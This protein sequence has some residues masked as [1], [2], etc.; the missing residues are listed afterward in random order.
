MYRGIPAAQLWI[1]PG[2]GHVPI[3][4]PLVPFTATALKFLQ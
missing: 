1:V 3:L 4:D 2:G